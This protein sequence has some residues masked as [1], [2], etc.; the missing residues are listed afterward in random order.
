MA[1][2]FQKCRIKDDSCG[3][4]RCGHPWTV[5]YREPGGRS[6]SQRE[7]TF[8]TKREARDYGIKA[9]NDK[10]EGR[11]LDPNA[12]KILVRDY[13]REWL[14]R[15]AIKETT[16][17]NYRNFFENHLI[18]RLGSKMLCNVMSS[19]IEKMCHAMCEAGLSRRTVYQS[20]M[21][22]LRSLFR[23]AVAEKRIS[24]SPVAL[25]SLP[26]VKTKRVDEKSLPNG[27]AV[28]ELAS[29]MRRDWAVSVWLMA[30]CGL[31][32]GEVLALRNTDLADGAMRLRRQFVR[33]KRDG[34]WKAELSPLK[35]REEGEWRDVPIPSFVERALRLHLRNHGVG[36]D[37]YLL[38]AHHGGHVLD[39]NYRTE[40]RRA[41]IK[42]G[43]ADESWTAHTLRHFFASSAIA[44]GLSLLEV[45]R[46]LG[47]ATIQI[48]ADI[49][50]HLTPDA[51]ARM[52]SVMDGALAAA[53]VS[54]ADS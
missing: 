27:E 19:D 41:V 44:G 7:K 29:A 28:A 31:R 21:V 12:G 30:G 11:Y 8:P 26:R 24:E 51:G 32:I 20:N 35:A 6:G 50:G 38:H 5:R 53:N 17:R 18:P 47:H 33:V 23:S 22:P 42:A 39:S 40:F 25:A 15:R 9:E 49:Y 54:C 43:F 34:V 10:R 13:S 48:T 36:E 14:S 4:S 45:S 3:R 46:W 37:G 16:R 52:R 1:T 2:I